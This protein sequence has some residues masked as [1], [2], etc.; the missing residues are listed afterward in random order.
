MVAAV[1]GQLES[2]VKIVCRKN[3]VVLERYNKVI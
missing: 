2:H 1:P 3:R